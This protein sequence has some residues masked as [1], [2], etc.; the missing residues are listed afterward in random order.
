MVASRMLEE[1]VLLTGEVEA[2]FLGDMLCQFNPA[3][4][5]IHAETKDQLR[6]IC[7]I[8][9]SNG[10]ARRLI[11][12]CT[13][14]IVPASVLESLPGPAYNFHPA[15]PSYPGSHP[16]SFAIYEGADLYGVTAHEMAPAVDAGAIVAVDWF[17]VPSN[18]RFTELETL[19]YKALVGL[20]SQL[21]ERLATDETPLPPS[22][23]VWFGH[24]RTNR[25]FERM[26]AFTADMDEEEIKRRFRAFG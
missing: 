26:Q 4:N 15:P 20:F 2:P 5:I 10:D 24:K 18:P 21:A 23:D 22:G 6:D 16:A 25:D 12:F 3:L 19:A 8:S 17:D 9:P 13:A 1:I 7:A 14:V 11:A